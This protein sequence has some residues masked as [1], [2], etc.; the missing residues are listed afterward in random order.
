MNVELIE[1][2]TEQTNTLPAAPEE[3]AARAL[4]ASK[5]AADLR[6][7]VEKHQPLK[8]IEVKDK[9]TRD[10]LDGAGMELRTARTTVARIAKDA[11]DDATKFSKAVIAAETELIAIT[12]PLEEALL[13]QRDQWDE[14]Q[15][16]IK[17]EREA[18]ERA[19]LLQ[20]KLTPA[21]T[22][23][24]L[25]IDQRTYLL[26]PSIFD[27]ESVGLT[28]DTGKFG[29]LCLTTEQELDYY[30]SRHPNVRGWAREYYVYGEPKGNGQA[31][32]R[33]VLDR[34]PN[35][36]DGMLTLNV[37]RYPLRE[38]EDSDDEPEIARRHHD[39]LV[40]WVL[41]R[42]YSERD[43]EASAP[44]RAANHLAAFTDRFGV[45][46]DANVMRKH[47]Q[48]RRPVIRPARGSM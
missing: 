18:A 43:I 34:A 48:Q 19:R 6:A 15:V 5:T 33:I 24:P 28:Q 7:L 17:A 8:G 42:A 1:P 14:E 40:D 32:M 39:G 22:Q 27:V 45:R 11:R 3:R 10:Q 35:L 20:D 30:A 36:A 26:H 21:V 4:N 41:Y 2:A 37:Y 46:R 29:D 44:N 38:M 9:A 47:R 31:G 13:A 12:E 25:V 16:R 23:I